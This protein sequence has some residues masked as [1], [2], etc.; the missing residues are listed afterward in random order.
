MLSRNPAVFFFSDR[1]CDRFPISSN[2]LKTGLDQM[3]EQA[4]WN[5]P[6]EFYS[7]LLFLRVSTIR[8]SRKVISKLLQPRDKLSSLLL[9]ISVLLVGDHQWRVD[10]VR[11]DLTS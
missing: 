1:A 8:E 11:S 5:L 10:R 9:D 7:S 3:M 6:G 4:R 2:E